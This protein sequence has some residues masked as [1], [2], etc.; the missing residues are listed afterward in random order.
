MQAVG[1]VVERHD[2]IPI[3]YILIYYQCRKEHATG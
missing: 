1:A 2:D 3:H